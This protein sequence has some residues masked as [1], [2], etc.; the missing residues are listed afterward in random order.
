MVS[1]KITFS[2]NV[3]IM[4]C[5]LVNF[6]GERATL[7]I[8]RSILMFYLVLIIDQSNYCIY[9]MLWLMN[10]KLKQH[11]STT[12]DNGRRASETREIPT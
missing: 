10:T 6:L 9:S 5:L 4:T 2:K 8:K 1:E 3:E 7:R 11:P 12:G